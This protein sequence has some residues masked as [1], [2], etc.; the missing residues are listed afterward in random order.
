MPATKPFFCLVFLYLVATFP[1]MAENKITITVD[2]VKGEAL[3]N[4]LSTLSLQKQKDNPR[5]TD[6]RIRKLHDQASNEIKQALQALGYYNPGIQSRLRLKDSKWKAHYDVNKGRPVKISKMDVQITGEGANDKAFNKLIKNLP[7]KQNQPLHHG[8]YESSK[9]ELQRLAATRGYFDAKF[10]KSKVKVN[11]KDLSAT[12]ILHFNTGIRYHFGKVSFSEMPIQLGKLQLYQPFKTGDPYLNSQLIK[13]QQNLSNTGFF[14][15]IKVHPFHQGIKGNSIPIQVSL[16]PQKQNRYTAGVGYG[17]DTGPRLKLGWDKRFSS[18]GNRMSTIAKLSPI[19][20]MLST[21]YIIPHFRI[22][23]AEL[24]FNTTLLYKNTGTSKSSSINAVVNYR[25]KRWGW[26]EIAS[27]NY[28]YENY[29]ISDT[30]Q[31]SKLLIPSIGWSKIV[32]DNPSYTTNGYRLGL[33][34]RGAIESFITD[35]SFIQG[36]LKGKYIRSLWDGGRFILRGNIGLTEVTDF[37]QLPASLRYFAGGDNSIRGFSYE[38]LGPK[39]DKGNVI[40]GKHLLVGSVEYQ[41]RVFENWSLAGFIDAGNAFNKFSGKIE[42]GTGVGVRWLSPV[43]LIG[44][45]L[46][47]GVSDP[48]LPIHFHIVIGPDL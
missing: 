25:H 5:L 8:K 43:G 36:S 33:S 45:D 11:L 40:G 39:D 17:T 6:S 9:G 22:K 30:K 46:A 10:L 48:N 7:L 47:V 19:L 31:S 32:T 16:T 35:T 18:Q 21:D 1:A 26:N 29:E 13:F 44:V 12:V 37:D 20:S 23:E 42:Y 2:G 28:L 27:L 14:S 15:E 3:E 34:I 38:G 4:I 24:S 41:H